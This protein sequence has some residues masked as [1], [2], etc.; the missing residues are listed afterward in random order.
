MLCSSTN[1]VATNKAVDLIAKL[2][3][4][5]ITVILN[6]HFS[7]DGGNLCS[8]DKVI[9]KRAIKDG[10]RVLSSYKYS[11]ADG[12]SHDVW[13]ITEAADDQGVREVTTVL[14]PSEY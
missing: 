9:N 4:V 14:L 3:G 6:R 11:D 7:G 8:E 2:P 13:V 12:K 10:S 5:N 1:V